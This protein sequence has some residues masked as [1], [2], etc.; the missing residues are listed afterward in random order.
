MIDKLHACI[1]ANGKNAVLHEY[2]LTLSFSAIIIS[3][4]FVVVGVSFLTE[5]L[6]ERSGNRSIVLK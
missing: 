4:L 3:R 1:H 2:M 6:M 5:Y